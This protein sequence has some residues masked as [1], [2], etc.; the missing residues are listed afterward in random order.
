FDFIKGSLPKDLMKGMFKKLKQAVK[1]LFTRWFDEAGGGEFDGSMGAHGVYKYLWNIA[2]KTM[3]KFPG[4]KFSRGGCYR[5]GDANY[6]GKHQAID[7]SY[8][9]SDN[10]NSKYFKPA[11][12]VFDNF[13]KQIGYVITQG[14][15]KTRGKFNRL[16]SNANGWSTWMDHDHYDHLHINGMW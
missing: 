8:P 5:T 6:H 15:I 14:K 1:D 3:K 12:W 7:I 11:N 13:K 16:G 9:A 4:M 2:K 10:H